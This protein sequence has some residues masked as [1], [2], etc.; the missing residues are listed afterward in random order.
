MSL[1]P[2]NQA[3]APVASCS[4]AGA[5]QNEFTPE[6]RASFVEAGPRVDSVGSGTREISLTP[7]SPH[8]AEPRGAFTTIYSK[9]QSARLCRLRIS[10]CFRL[11]HG[12]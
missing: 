8:L 5:G 11:P 12:G 9:G 3:A 2:E 7:P 4:S 1:Q 10:S 6:E